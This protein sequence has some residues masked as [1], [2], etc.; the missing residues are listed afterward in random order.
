MQSRCSLI[1]QDLVSAF[2]AHADCE[3]AVAMSAYMRNLFPFFGI[4]AQD[5]RR[6]QQATLRSQGGLLTIEEA[7]R[8]AEDLYAHQERELHYAACDILVKA[9][10]KKALGVLSDHER[11]EYLNRTEAL[12]TQHQWW[13]TVDVLAPRVAGGLLRGHHDLLDSWTLR[14][15]KSDDFWL[16]RSAIISQLHYKQET[17]AEIVFRGILMRASSREFFVQKAAGW[18]LRQYAYVN[19]S[20]VVEFVTAHP[21]LSRLT[22]REALKRLVVSRSRGKDD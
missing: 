5:R 21:E 9:L 6:L 3:R 12:L 11:T 4:S 7:F 15:A 10:S 2:S 20:A 1:V 19:A 18:A 16:Q 22:K 14:W 8:C 13:D 17:D